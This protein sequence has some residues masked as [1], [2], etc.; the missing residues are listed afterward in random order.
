MFWKS[1]PHLC[2]HSSYWQQHPSYSYRPPKRAWSPDQ[3]VGFK[4]DKKTGTISDQWVNVCFSCL[5]FFFHWDM[6]DIVI[7][8]HHP[9][10][11]HDD[12]QLACF[13]DEMKLES[14]NACLGRQRVT[15]LQLVLAYM[16]WYMLHITWQPRRIGW[17][18]CLCE[19]TSYWVSWEILALWRASYCVWNM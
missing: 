13:D 6:E 9:P 3:A 12:Q 7:P 19:L 14:C 11:H 8:E 10:L 4:R 15:H 17:I 2:R 1:S 18:D 16:V 5:C